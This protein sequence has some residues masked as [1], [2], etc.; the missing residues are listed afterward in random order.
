MD[1]AI[2]D[3][4]YAV[5]QLRKNIGFT[6]TATFVQALGISTAITIFGRVE[7]ALINH[8]HIA[9]NPGW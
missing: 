4:W 1:T 5:R 7:A 3:I 9:I 8:C 6:Y 2:Q